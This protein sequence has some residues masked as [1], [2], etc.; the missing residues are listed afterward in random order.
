MKLQLLVVIGLILL[1]L[2]VVALAVPTFTY[3]TTE[4]VADVGFFKIATCRGRTRSCSIRSWVVSQWLR[5]SFWF[6][7]AL[8]VLVPPDRLAST[9]VSR[10]MPAAPSTVRSH[11]EPEG[12]HYHAFDRN[13]FPGACGRREPDNGLRR[14]LTGGFHS[15]APLSRRLRRRRSV[16]AVRTRRGKEVRA[17][18]LLRLALRTVRGARRI[19]LSCATRGCVA[20]LRHLEGPRDVASSSA[21]SLLS[22]RAPSVMPGCEARETTYPHPLV[23]WQW[24]RKWKL[25]L[26]ASRRSGTRSEW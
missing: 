8:F 20:Y 13:P 21:R 3:F 10:S 24:K 19:D 16:R 18:V 25:R 26:P 4:R 7:W 11:G 1:V 14:L 5:A 15:H 9:P 17:P 2:G 22:R 23:G 12:E 6:F